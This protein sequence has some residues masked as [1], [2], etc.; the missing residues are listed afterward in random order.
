MSKLGIFNGFRR[1]K[2]TYELYVDA[3]RELGVPYEIVDIVGDNWVENVRSSDC[4]GFLVRPTPY[5]SAWKQMFDERLYYVVHHLKRTIYPSYGDLLLYEN[6]R[7]MAYFLQVHDLPCPRTHVFYQL[8]EALEF[9]DQTPLPVV[10]KTHIGA[11]GTGVKII[12]SRSS[13]KRLAQQI[14]RIGYPRSIHT[15]LKGLL[16]ARRIHVPYH[17]FDPEYKSIILQEYLPDVLE[18]RMIRIGNSYFGHQKLRKGDFHSGSSLV[19]WVEPPEALLRFAKHVCDAGHFQ[20]MC[21]DVF[22][23]KA[24]RYYVNELQAVFGSYNPSQMYIDGKPGRF[25]YNEREDRFEFEE[26][27]F[28]QNGSCNLRVQH[29]LEILN[30]RA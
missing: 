3:C 19:G 26:G 9:L 20:S 4:A 12:R 2:D 23:D 24:G 7:H 25:W 29:L 15:N 27:Y 21:L 14:F 6:K 5:Y 18:W 1:G 16:G 28:N 30:E 13:G 17:F 11:Q 10:F 8:D 22:E